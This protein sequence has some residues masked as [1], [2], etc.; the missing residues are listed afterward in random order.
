MEVGAIPTLKDHAAAAKDYP[1]VQAKL[2]EH[3]EATQRHAELVARCIERLGDHPSALKEAVGSVVGK[4]TG[5]ANLPAKD[6]VIKNALGDYAAENFEIICYRS[7]IAGAEQLGDYDTVSVCREIL[8]DEEDMAAWLEAQIAPLTQAFLTMNTGEDANGLKDVAT[9]VKETVTELGEKSRE[10]AANVGTRNALLGAGALLAGAG[11]AM[12][13][14]QALKRDPEEEDAALPPQYVSDPL[15]VSKDEL[16]DEGALGSVGIAGWDEQPVE[17][18]TDL[19][20]VELD[21]VE[22]LN[23]NDES[24]MMVGL[25][26]AED[27][28][29]ATTPSEIWL[30]PGPYTG[31]GPKAY[32]S[33]GDPLGQEA[34]LRLT[35]HGQVDASNIEITVDKGTVL[36]EGTVVSE[37]AKSLAEEA[38]RSLAGVSDV[39]NLLEVH[40]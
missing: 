6:T 25:L 33:A 39:Q 9:K 10:A 12:L 19:V 21:D 31:M 7:L 20:A 34:A 30:T 37:E 38:I 22:M 32:E 28:D 35:Q 3:V 29:G 40:T 13:I 27:A 17:E 11:A 4:V 16:A 15:E 24:A 23:H 18:I 8:Q 2:N 36:L 5:L 14:G 1:E 26:A